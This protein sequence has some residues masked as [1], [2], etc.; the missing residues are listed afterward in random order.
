M[1]LQE[2]RKILTASCPLRAVCRV[3]PGAH[4][5]GVGRKVA[6]APVHD[7]QAVPLRDAELLGDLVGNV[8]NDVV[9]LVSDSILDIVDCVADGVA[10]AAP[11]AAA[12]LRGLGWVIL[13]RTGDELLA[14]IRNVDLQRGLVRCSFFFLGTEARG[15]FFLTYREHVVLFKSLLLRAGAGEQ[16]QHGQDKGCDRQE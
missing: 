14:E 16:G 7:V 13:G 11:E 9:D 5:G 3:V 6:L 12:G 1:N 8:A 2:A 10:Y 15:F 4:G